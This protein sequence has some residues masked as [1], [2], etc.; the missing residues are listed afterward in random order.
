[1]SQAPPQPPPPPPR[2]FSTWM[3]LIL[4]DYRPTT[5]RWGYTVSYHATLQGHP[6]NSLTTG[7]VCCRWDHLPP[8]ITKYTP[9]SE[10]VLSKKRYI[11][12]DV[13]RQA[14]TS[15]RKTNAR[16]PPP[17]GDVC[18][19]PGHGPAVSEGARSIHQQ[20]RASSPRVDQKPHK[21]PGIPGPRPTAPG[22]TCGNLSVELT[23]CSSWCKPDPASRNRLAMT[24]KIVSGAENARA[25]NY[26]K[27]ALPHLDQA[28]YIHQQSASTGDNEKETSHRIS[29]H[30][31]TG[32]QTHHPTRP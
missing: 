28:R 29:V 16:G 32:Y 26:E 25:Y 5:A 14:R 24:S 3:P 22:R 8:G 7:Q 4:R 21:R 13:Y 30:S 23:A 15:I 11:L 2:T 19:E 1:M 18:R 31:A 9:L 17:L 10:S 27:E 12:R 6:P 20:T